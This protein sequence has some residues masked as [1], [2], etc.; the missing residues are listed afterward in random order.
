MF[1]PV[2]KPL[3]PR[4]RNVEKYLKSM[5]INRNYS[6]FGPLMTSL[7]NRYAVF[8]NV[9]SEQVVCSANATLALL[10]S[11]ILSDSETI[12]V[13][14]FTFPATIQAAIASGKKVIIEDI[15]LDTWMLPEER[16]KH[17]A[18]ILVLPFGS[19]GEFGFGTTQASLRI[20]DAAASIGN[21]ENK[22]SDLHIN[23]VIIF[24]LHATKILGVGEGAISVF[25]DAKLASEYRSWINFGFNG[26]RN[27]STT[28][29]NAKMPEV[30]AAYGHAALDLWPT[31][32]KEWL[33]VNN[34]QVKIES[35]LGISPYFSNKNNVSPYWIVE[36]SSES[37]RDSVVKQLNLSKI[38][39]RLWW[40]K[41]CHKMTAFQH[42]STGEFSN[43]D[44]VSS[45]ILGLPKFRDLDNVDIN[46]IAEALRSSLSK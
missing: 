1:I 16:I 20:I 44:D 6:N 26:S 7:E 14:A 22:L 24:S 37:I 8:F 2:M 29:I 18:R 32:K 30:S 12:I 28:G 27:S 36:F 46:L 42:L 35:E 40:E 31:E 33:Q 38:D 19:E 39:S 10:G 45:R 17:E 43:S 9:K 13:P 23:E 25:G 4:Y 11:C 5:D 34:L 41:G 21:Y 3:L 15:D